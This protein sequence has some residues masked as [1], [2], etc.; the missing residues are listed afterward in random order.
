M[1]DDINDKD[2]ATE[3][4]FN[5]HV[6][7]FLFHQIASPLVSIRNQVSNILTGRLPQEAMESRIKAIDQMARLALR[8]LENFR[9]ISEIHSLS[10]HYQV[11]DIK[12]FLK[13]RLLAFESMAK[14]NGIDLF[15]ETKDT[16]NLIFES[17]YSI[18]SLAVDNIIENAIKFSYGTKDLQGARSS[19][20]MVLIRAEL[21]DRQLKIQITNWGHEISSAEKELIFTKFYRGSQATKFVAGTGIGLYISNKCVEALGGKLEAFSNKHETTFMLTLNIANR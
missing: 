17:D 19:K 3:A 12:N 14:V 20:P 10:P 18:L 7:R 16:E 9:I 5:T 4:E 6:S 15:V 11:I 21:Y 8:Q 13:D 2:F 1:S